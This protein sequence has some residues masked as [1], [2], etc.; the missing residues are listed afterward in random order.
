[1]THH[2]CIID[3]SLNTDKIDDLQAH[4]HEDYFSQTSMLS[5]TSDDV[6]MKLLLLL[7]DCLNILKVYQIIMRLAESQKLDSV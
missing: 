2:T 6:I 7:S 1:M 4:T 3:C 5:M